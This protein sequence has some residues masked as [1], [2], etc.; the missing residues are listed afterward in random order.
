MAIILLIVLAVK[1]IT[2]GG[3]DEAGPADPSPTSVEPTDEPTTD[4]ASEEPTEDATEEATD[5]TGGSTTSGDYEFLAVGDPAVVADTGGEPIVEVRMLQVDRNWEP[6]GSAL[7]SEPDGDY[8]AMEFEFTTLPALADYSEGTYSFAGFELGMMDTDGNK[9]ADVS[10]IAGILC[11]DSD[12]RTPT[13]MV[14]GEVYTGWALVDVPR[15]PGGV[16]WEPWLDFSGTQ[17]TYA[18]DLADY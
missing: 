5:D 8:V 2:G 1:M 12:E 16:L 6:S 4:E 15:E 7:C 18:W 10:G 17:P 3:D 14:P 9:I 11:L 13:E